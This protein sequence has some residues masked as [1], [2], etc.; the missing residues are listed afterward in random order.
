MCFFF[1]TRDRRSRDL[2]DAIGGRTR[3]ASFRRRRVDV[4]AMSFPATRATSEPRPGKQAGSPAT[5][6][7]SKRRAYFFKQ[8]FCWPI[9]TPCVPGTRAYAATRVVLSGYTRFDNHHTRTM[10]VRFMPMVM[11]RSQR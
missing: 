7:V 1:A 2:H 8:R 4:L 5:S 6:E 3:R 11:L 9:E 10:F